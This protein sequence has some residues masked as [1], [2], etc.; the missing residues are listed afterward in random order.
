MGE[1]DLAEKILAD[2][3]DVFADIVNVLLFHGEQRIDPDEL[4]P[5][6]AI[7]QY[8]ADTG[9]LHE[10]E[11]D[12]SKYWTQYGVR[13]SLFG[14]EN[15][16]KPERDMPFRVI[17]YDGASY[18]QQLLKEQKPIPVITMVLH[19]G[20]KHRW[21]YP[22]SIKEL[23]NIPEYLDEYVNDYRIFV[24]DIAWLT[25]EQLAMFQSDFGIV[26]RHFVETR[27]NK[28][29]VPDDPRVIKHVDEVLKLLSV[30]SQDNRYAE[31]LKTDAG[32]EVKNM[33]DV[34]ERL[35][36]RGVKRGMERGMEHG[37]KVGELI[38]K[39]TMC[40]EFG[41]S[42]EETAKKLNISVKTLKE[43]LEKRDLQLQR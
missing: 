24:Y 35:E 36:Q 29:Y 33:C 41:L 13:F 14:L 8:K 1:K 17:G 30:L 38:G 6:S 40:K 26:A 39:I 9:K 18:R 12:V 31:I 19:F 32:E 10:Q 7:S 34:A 21:N 5:A 37:M 28:N 16:T 20:I 3:N 42:D 15:Q 27:R 25:D 23:L 11:R 4:Q 43:T 22:F 2:Y